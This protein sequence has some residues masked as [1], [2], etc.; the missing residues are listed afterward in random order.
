VKTG[1]TG[2]QRFGMC[3]KA[4]EGN[5]SAGSFRRKKPNGWCDPHFIAI[6][7][8]FIRLQLWRLSVQRNGNSNG[9]EPKRRVKW[10]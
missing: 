8:F 3:R 1:A 10:G 4:K 5:F 7:G 6:F 9:F 2:L